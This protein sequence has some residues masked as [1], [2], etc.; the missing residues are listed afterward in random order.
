[1]VS[2]ELGMSPELGTQ[3]NP[4]GEPVA[5]CDHV[6]REAERRPVG[7]LARVGRFHCGSGAVMALVITAEMTFVWTNSTPR[8]TNH[9]KFASR[10]RAAASGPIPSMLQRSAEPRAIVHQSRGVRSGWRPS[11]ATTLAFGI[12]LS[13]R[14]AGLR[15]DR[16]GDPTA[17]SG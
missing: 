6:L 4:L 11:S 9:F 12:P 8:S 17:G 7:R 5:V 16:R 10:T 1:M 14:A 15:R 3:L 13:R 2:P